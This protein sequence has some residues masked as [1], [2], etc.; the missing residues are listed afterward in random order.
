MA[1]SVGSFMATPTGAYLEITLTQA[2][3][4]NTTYWFA[5]KS[6][7][8]SSVYFNSKETTTRTSP[9]QLVIVAGP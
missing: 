7:G 1:A 4:P 5:I 9:P 6:A 2:I 8:T 3:S